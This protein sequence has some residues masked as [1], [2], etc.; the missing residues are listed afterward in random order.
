[1]KPGDLSMPLT[2]KESNR[3][4]YVKNKERI[5]QRSLANY[6][7]KKVYYKSNFRKYY[8]KNRDAMII[9]TNQS[10][11]KNRERIRGRSLIRYWPEKTGEEALLADQVLYDRQEGV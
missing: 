3:K 2:R 11:E 6:A 5:N 8:S 9:S 1:M 7:N 10:R 4:Y